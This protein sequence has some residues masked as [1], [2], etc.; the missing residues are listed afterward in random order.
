M[1]HCLARTRLCKKPLSLAALLCTLGASPT[2]AQDN[3]GGD[4]EANGSDTGQ[5]CEVAVQRLDWTPRRQVPPELRDDQ[6]LRCGGRY[7]D[8]LGHLDRSKSPA[9]SDINANAGSTELRGNTVILSDEVWMQQGYRQLRA[10]GATLDR[11]QRSGTLTGNVELREPGLLLKGDHAEVYTRTGEAKL[12]ASH[13]LLHEQQLRGQADALSRD[14]G[15]ILHVHGGALSF[16]PPGEE[17]WRIRAEELELNIEE[18]LGTA[19]GA[20]VDVAGVPIIYLPW[21]RFPIDDRR[22]TGFLW[23]DIGSDTKG[24][25]DMSVPVLSLIHI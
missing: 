4:C 23:P 7:T 10:D 20:K 19:R 2:W 17:D 16:C 22:R 18:G 1:F 25:L 24:G 21:M 5:A 6:C 9:I 8:P 15:G 3:S 11:E 13:F 12:D 14:A